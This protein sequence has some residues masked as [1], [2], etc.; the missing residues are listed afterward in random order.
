MRASPINVAQ[1]AICTWRYLFWSVVVCYISGHR[2]YLQVHARTSTLLINHRLHSLCSLLSEMTA[3]VSLNCVR[4]ECKTNKTCTWW[5]NNLPSSICGYSA[6]AKNKSHVREGAALQTTSPP[7]N[8]FHCLC[9]YGS[10]SIKRM[11]YYR[12]LSC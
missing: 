1:R 6:N 4:I 5:V 2:A 9:I 11:R 3:T 8:C 10:L 7:R 12:N